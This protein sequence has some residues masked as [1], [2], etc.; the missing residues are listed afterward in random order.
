MKWFRISLVLLCC[1]LFSISS[2]GQQGSFKHYNIQE[3]LIQSQVFSFT[4]DQRDFLWMAT[5]GG[6]AI[7]DGTD[8]EYLTKND[9]LPSNTIH[10]IYKDSRNRIWIST[11]KGVAY[12]DGKK[13]HTIPLEQHE[14][15]AA[16][17][18]LQKRFYDANK[19]LYYLQNSRLYV[20]K[21]QRLV[22]I[23]AALDTID[24]LLDGFVYK[25]QLYVLSYQRGLLKVTWEN[26]KLSYTPLNAKS[27]SGT[28]YGALQV[29]SLSGIITLLASD[30]LHSLN[31]NTN[32]LTP[33]SKW[34]EVVKIGV[35]KYYKDK[36]GGEWLSN[37][38][39]GVYYAKG[40]Q[41]VHL[42]KEEGLTDN[43]ILSIYEDNQGNIWLG[44][45]G[46]GVFRFNYG[47]FYLLDKNRYF[48]GQN[49]SAIAYSTSSKKLLIGTSKGYLYQMPIGNI[50]ALKLEHKFNSITAI[51]ENAQKEIILTDP[52]T[53]LYTY[54]KSWQTLFINDTLK[55]YQA[56]AYNSFRT[57]EAAIINGVLW[58]KQQGEWI[59]TSYNSNA[60]I[61]KFL[62]ENKI[63]LGSDDGAIIYDLQQEKVLQ[64]LA[65]GSSISDV[66]VS[67]PHIIIG[68]DDKGLLVYNMQDQTIEE[69]NTNDGLSCNFVYSIFIDQNVVWI[70]TG[71]GVDKLNLA[72]QQHRIMNY[73]TVHGWGA[74]EANATAIAKVDSSIYIG[75]NDGLLVLNTQKESINQFAPKIILKKLLVFS[76]EMDLTPYAQEFFYDGL[77]P[78]NPIFPSNFTHLTFDIKAVILGVDKIKYRYQLLGSN[79]ENIYETDQ[80]QIVFTNL[81]PGKYKLDLWSTNS[82]GQ[83]GDTFYR[84]E[85]EI[86]TLFV[87]TWYFRIAILFALLAVYFLFRWYK[88][89]LKLKR[90]AREQS[91]KLAE[92][93]RV[94]QRTAEDFHDEIGNKLTKINLLSSMAK[95][96]LDQN[97]EAFALVNQLQY[98]TQ[99]LYKGAKDIIWSLQ[100][101]SNYLHHIVDRIVWNAEEM[102]QLASIRL[103]V[104][105]DFEEDVNKESYQLVKMEDEVSRNMILIFKEVFNNIIKY[106]ETQEVSMNI[107]IKNKAIQFSVNDNGKGFDINSSNL[108]RGNGLNNM[109]RRAQRIHA[110]YQLSSELGMGTK[111]TFI[112]PF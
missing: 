21:N 43:E 77:L 60:T 88:N 26:E 112:L 72:E 33:I 90:E 20:L 52:F 78:K 14:H 105:T 109:Q 44:S 55:K 58:K 22:H 41:V 62:T 67:V 7:F 8:W 71:C 103:K 102:M 106:A 79:D 28:I 13:L 35:Y 63:I 74:I 1:W 49:I 64:H 56:N 10:N 61:I 29:D 107:L 30:G 19:T 84:Y 9:G 53:H 40:D 31:I 95:T 100:P 108:E 38:K 92:Q 98:Q 65:A 23:S 51:H 27:G 15:S 57:T 25:S 45:N 11:T 5:V 47:P 6:L 93:D 32:K 4:Q 66:A 101:Q 70:G 80:S 39:G 87:Q 110:H 86:K 12:F 3:G 81:G 36:S 46:D 97:S 2:F 69:L 42:G 34:K 83:W 73:S 94:K 54:K 89:K 48:R 16:G 96:K 68:T 18:I 17:S 111:V 24:N 91:L 50:G 85:F 99:S 59:K 75:T 104:T 82:F 37:T 76:K